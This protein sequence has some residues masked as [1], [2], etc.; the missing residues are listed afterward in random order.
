MLQH[1]VE[2][3]VVDLQQQ[4]QQQKQQKQ[5]QATKASK[6]K[7]KATTASNN[8]QQNARQNRTD[9]FSQD[10]IET[11]RNQNPLDK[12]RMKMD[13]LVPKGRETLTR[14]RRTST[15][16]VYPTTTTTTTTTTTGTRLLLIVLLL[17]LASPYQVGVVV[18]E[19]AG[20]LP[21]QHPQ[22]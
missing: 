21:S 17:L 22:Q 15:S 2:T 10:Y 1:C 11:E 18:V 20:F 6:S 4:Q 8:K 5:Q 13:R 16:V 3:L 12:K 9:L 7:Q 14:R 19:G